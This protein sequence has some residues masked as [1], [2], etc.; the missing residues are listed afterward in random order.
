MAE[1]AKRFLQSYQQDHPSD[2]KFV[3]RTTK[4]M[5]KTKEAHPPGALGVGGGGGGGGGGSLA[6]K[7]LC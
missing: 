6:G 3:S 7:D 4:E 5:E 1:E 2:L